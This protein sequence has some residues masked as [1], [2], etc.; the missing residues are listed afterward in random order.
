MERS[1]K[2]R[3]MGFV[4]SFAGAEALMRRGYRRVYLQRIQSSSGAVGVEH[5]MDHGTDG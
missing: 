1:D 2:C 5:M 3:S 4:D